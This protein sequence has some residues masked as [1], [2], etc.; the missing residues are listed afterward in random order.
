MNLHPREHSGLCS[1]G[2][3]GCHLLLLQGSPSCLKMALQS[4][5]QL[6]QPSRAHV[7]Q[8]GLLRVTNLLARGVW[9]AVD[10]VA[11]ALERIRLTWL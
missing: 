7:L 4:L 5:I 8:L 9:S 6:L 11:V 10:R 1:G 3:G 2:G